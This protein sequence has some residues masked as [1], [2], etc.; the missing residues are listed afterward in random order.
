MSGEEKGWDFPREWAEGAGRC[1]RRGRARG[2]YRQSGGEQSLFSCYVKYKTLK[3]NTTTLNS[4]PRQ[5]RGRRR[6]S[7]LQESF[8]RGAKRGAGV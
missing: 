2:T 5:L 1:G 3:N 6:F 7:E 8:V 4:D